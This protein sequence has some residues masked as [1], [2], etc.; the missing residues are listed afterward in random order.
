M[1]LLWLNLAIAAIAQ[2]IAFDNTPLNQIDVLDTDP[3]ELSNQFLNSPIDSN[4]DFGGLEDYKV[5]SYSLL[6]LHKQLVEY[7]SITN[8]ELAVGLFLKQY[9]LSIG[10]HVKLQEVAENRYNVYGFRGKINTPK[11]VLLTSH[12][13]V[14]L[15]YI[16]Y[17]VNGTKIFGRGT[18]DAKGS[19]ATQIFA[20]LSLAEELE[21][22]DVALLYVVGEEVNGIGMDK[23]SDDLDAEWD[24]AI[25]GEPTELKL[26]VGHKGNYMFDLKVHGKA[27]HSGYP[28]LGLSATEILIPLLNDL[29]N[30]DL[31]KSDLLGPTTINIG[32]INGGIAANI[33]PAEASASV[34]IRVADD[35]EL[36]DKKVRKIV[37]NVEHV[38][39]DVKPPIEPQFLDYKVPG[40]DSIVL[41]YATDIP[42]LT[43][44]LSKRYLYGPGTIHVAH[45]DNEHVENQDLLGAVEGYKRLIKHILGQ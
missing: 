13:D 41:A 40:F 9:L 34:F 15:P 20:Y 6:S 10:L 4:F 25:F 23:A 43:K 17:S 29:L 21:D 45:A 42:H 31:P 5:G 26:G 2:Q 44:K 37:E 3:V 28:E 14:V 39:F 19:V 24:V 12:I 11:K 32:M 27:S 16:P 7:D 22:D 18:C 30:L 33:I 35:I 36:I 1:K 38:E 8:D